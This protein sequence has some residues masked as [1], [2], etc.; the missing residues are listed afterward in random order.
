ME[1]EMLKSIKFELSY[2]KC[3]IDIDDLD[4]ML[5][6]LPAE[7]YIELYIKIKNHAEK[8]LLENN[9]KVKEYIEQL[10][11]E[12]ETYKDI[13]SIV[14][15]KI[16][17]LTQ[18]KDIDKLKSE[19]WILQNKLNKYESREQKLIEKLEEDIREETGYAKWVD[20]NT[21]RISSAVTTIISKSQYAKEILEILKKE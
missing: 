13:K 16:T 1:N 14:N 17:E 19:N 6:K 5:L 15:T 8:A 18:I 11:K 21:K 20:S 4:K 7:K 10:E 2:D 9:K 12:L 3:E